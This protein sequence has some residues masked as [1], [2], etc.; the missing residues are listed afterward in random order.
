[1]NELVYPEAAVAAEIRGHA[2]GFNG[3]C[4]MTGNF[5]EAVPAGDNV[6]CV[7]LTP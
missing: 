2:I 7:R 4:R 3:D 5:P 6:S 1:M